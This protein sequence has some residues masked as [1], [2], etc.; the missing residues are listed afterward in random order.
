MFVGFV[1]AKAEAFQTKRGDVYR[2]VGRGGMVPFLLYVVCV[3]LCLNYMQGDQGAFG[4]AV[5]TFRISLV[6]T[7]LYAFVVAFMYL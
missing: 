7:G 2:H 1:Y 6:V 4:L 5:L 3:W